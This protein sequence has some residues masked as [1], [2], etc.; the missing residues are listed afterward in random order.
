MKQVAVGI[1]RRNGLVLACQRMKDA[2]Y[3]LKWEFPGGKLEQGE[4]PREAL[5]R[6]LH[7]E[8]GIH[9]LVGEEFYRQEWVYTEGVAEPEKPGAF[10]V[11]YF[12]VDE[13]TG[14]L[15]NNAFEAVTWVQPEE[16]QHM[17]I[18]EGNRAAINLLEQHT[19]NEESRSQESTSPG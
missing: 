4:T 14:E 6:E 17:D 10:R 15:V 2:R 5:V 16:L 1:I 19:R 9:A 7:E 3:P 12:L 13:F 18:L 8:L 11:F